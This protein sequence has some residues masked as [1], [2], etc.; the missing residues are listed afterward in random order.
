MVC[1]L[2]DSSMEPLARSKS[3]SS[4]SDAVQLHLGTN[5]GG[6]A[7]QGQKRSVRGED[8]PPPKRTR[9]SPV[10]EQAQLATT[11]QSP[12]ACFCA[13]NELQR[14]TSSFLACMIP[15][16]CLNCVYPSSSVHVEV[17]A[18]MLCGSGHPQVTGSLLP[19]QV[20]SPRLLVPWTPQSTT[21]SLLMQRLPMG[22]LVHAAL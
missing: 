13:S 7:A 18:P 10:P 21:G 3:L 22:T 19:S 5:L 8:S 20:T 16:H 4:L 12:S 2:V 15:T 14:Y 9:P 11:R 17:A 1:L 6:M